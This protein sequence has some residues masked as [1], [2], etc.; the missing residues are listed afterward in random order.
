MKRNAFLPLLVLLG[1]KS[2]PPL[3][4][5]ESV[6]LNRYAGTWYEWARFDHSFERGCTC[7]TAEYTLAE[8]HVV[9]KN[10]CFENGTSR[11]TEG[12]AFPVEGS[13]NA[14][15]KVQFFWPFKGNYYII[16]LGPNY[17]YALVG[18]PSR[19]YLWVLGR[20]QTPDEAVLKALLE[21]AESLG[22]DTSGILRNDCTAAP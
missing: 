1:C 19:K 6:E 18:D 15:L 11:T 20:T 12:K 22:F 21:K 10:T 4:V 8:E 7:A 14:R 2:Y 13:N 16:E 3:P 17:D 9:V 5:V